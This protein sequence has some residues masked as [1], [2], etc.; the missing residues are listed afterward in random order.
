MFVSQLSALGYMLAG[1]AALFLGWLVRRMVRKN[2][3]AIADAVYWVL[4][5]FLRRSLQL[6]LNAR[7]YHRVTHDS[8]NASHLLVPGSSGVAL[9]TDKSFVA[10]SLEQA[11]ASS[12][13]YTHS[14]LWDAGSRLRIIGDPGSGKSTL[15][16][17]LL[18][19]ECRI[20]MGSPRKAKLSILVNLKEFTP[21]GTA[22][23]EAQLAAWAVN[24]LKTRV[25]KVRGYRMELLFESFAESETTGVLLLLDGLDEVSTTNYDR[26]VAGVNAIANRLTEL[27]PANVVVVTMRKNFYEQT[28]TDLDATLPQVLSVRPFSANDIYEF[29]TRWPFDLKVH[30][31]KVNKVY[32]EL[33]DRPN[34]RDMCRNPL[35]LAMY[36]ANYESVGAEELPDTRTEFYAKVAKE[37]LVWRRSRQAGTR[38]ARNTLER[39]REQVLGRL[40]LQNLIDG[41]MPVNS[42][43]RGDAIDVVKKVLRVVSDDEAEAIF[44]EIAKETGI[45]EEEKPDESFRFIH[46]TFCEYLAAVECVKGDEGGH[47]NLLRLHRRLRASG[48]AQER[49][50]LV[51]VIPFACALLTNRS[52]QMQALSEVAELG[53]WELFGRCLLETQSYDHPAWPVYEREEGGYLQNVPQEQWNEEWLSRVQFFRT[54]LADATASASYAGN[55]RGPEKPF[56]MFF[57]ELVGR[58]RSKLVT[59]LEGFASRDSSAALRFAEESKLDLL[60]EKPELLVKS[61]VSPAFLSLALER[62]KNSEEK[63]PW[64]IVLAEASLRFSVV[65]RELEARPCDVYFGPSE[66][67][68][69]GWL[70]EAPDTVRNAC[71][72]RAWRAARE[73]SRAT[74]FISLFSLVDKPYGGA[75]KTVLAAV[76]SMFFGVVI[77]LS[78]QMASLR[79]LSEVLAIFIAF[80]LLGLVL[81]IEF[82]FLVLTRV[83]RH[84][85]VLWRRLVN[86]HEDSLTSER[87]EEERSV[88]LSS[89]RPVGRGP[90]SRLTLLFIRPI[91][92]VTSVCHAIRMGHID[93]D[94]L[95]FVGQI[96]GRRLVLSGTGSARGRLFVLFAET[97]DSYRFVEHVRRSDGSVRGTL[98]SFQIRG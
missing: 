87:S 95:D 92:L 24:Y 80:L 23:T 30:P 10:L 41:E 16:K 61:C 88:R 15:V 2:R 65:A 85:A 42:I 40:A 93:I 97:R 60:R 70:F 57:S 58:N 1:P 90:V 49:S 17:R 73:S 81:V 26:T 68:G 64:A 53:D 62:L 31:A 34:L 78:L 33:S 89:K 44:D 38:I 48:A 45:T 28:R 37:L 98:Q 67:R 6:N 14:N 94:S 8:R 4:S 13:S 52:A 27:G 32:G 19:D 46:L 54:V 86:L 22:R 84:R 47:L 43:Q 29:I 25:A 50:R 77:L 83:P 12:K 71:L 72:Y 55:L 82:V 69:Q 35:I 63:N 96:E 39:Q 21:P 18:R 75:Y 36:V 56:S 76:S 11:F 66:V 79:S 5:R 59:L 91:A 20:G 74:P 9:E 51:E 3:G 7:H